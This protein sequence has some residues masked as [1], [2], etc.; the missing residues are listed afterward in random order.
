MVRRIWES[1]RSYHHFS[2]LGINKPRKIASV[3]CFNPATLPFQNAFWCALVFSLKN[4]L[5][6][7]INSIYSLF[8]SRKSLIWHFWFIFLAKVNLLKYAPNIQITFY[9]KIFRTIYNLKECDFLYSNYI[10]LIKLFL[11]SISIKIIRR[12]IVF[13]ESIP[14]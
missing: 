8:M 9:L 1:S 13:G 3:Q 6:C 14:Y 11:L 5:E 12:S 2:F 4:K 10:W 7:Y